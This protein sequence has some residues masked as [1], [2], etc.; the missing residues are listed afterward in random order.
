M[1]VVFTG[2]AHDAEG[3][4]ILRA[5]LKKAAQQIG[6]RVLDNWTPAA[7]LL[8]ASRIDT[9]K[10]KHAAERRIPVLTYPEFLAVLA[11]QG[12]TP[13]LAA[14]SKAAAN[15]FVDDVP[16]VNHARQK[17]QPAEAWDML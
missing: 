12:A 3:H 8:V 13:T 5:D 17:K 16:Q 2:A 9:V 15:D 7:Q 11:K 14:D 4:P 1:Y 6:F 10:A